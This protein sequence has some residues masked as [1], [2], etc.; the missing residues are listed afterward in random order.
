MIQTIDIPWLYDRHSHVSLYAA[1][2]GCPDLSGR[3]P[4]EA[5][6]LLRDLPGP[7][8]EQVI[9]FTRYDLPAHE[10]QEI[11]RK[12][13]LMGEINQKQ[14]RPQDKPRPLK[15]LSAADQKRI[16]KI[17]PELAEEVKGE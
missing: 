9:D 17:C 11:T 4:D 1:L 7:A 13:S 15:E 16:M 10:A 5:L 2:Q 14:T 8:P 6:A 12:W 3:T